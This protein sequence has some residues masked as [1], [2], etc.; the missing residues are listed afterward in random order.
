MPIPPDLQQA[1]TRLEIIKGALAITMQ[2][3][4]DGLAVAQG[5]LDEIKAYFDEHRPQ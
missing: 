3:L 1:F 4:Q 5:A 2:N